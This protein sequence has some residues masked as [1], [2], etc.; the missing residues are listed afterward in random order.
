MLFFSMSKLD[1]LTNFQYPVEKLFFLVAEWFGG[2]EAVGAYCD[3]A[4]LCCVMLRL[5]SVT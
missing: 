2:V 5:V 3:R 4:M 1:A